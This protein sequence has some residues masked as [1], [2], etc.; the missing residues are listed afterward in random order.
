MKWTLF[1]VVTLA[2]ISIGCQQNNTPKLNAGKQFENPADS[3]NELIKESP[4]DAQLYFERAQLHYA[5]RDVASSL[6]DV[7]R[8][9]KLDSGNVEFYILLA[10]L[11]L[12]NK[13][14]RD[15]KDALLKAYRINPTDTRV[16]LKLGELYMIVND[17]DASFRYLNEALQQ[18]IHLAEAYRLKGFN[19]K[20]SGDTTNAVSSFQ[21]AI[22]QDPDDYDSYLQLGL[23][24]SSILNPLAL[25]Y[26]DN[27][28]RVRPASLEAMYAKALHLQ[29]IGESR[30]AIRLYDQ[31]IEANPNFFNAHYNKGFVYLEQ[32]EKY[33]SAA[34]A[35]TQ[36]INYGPENYF[37]A[38]YNR[39]LANERMGNKT[40]AKEDYKLALKQN[41]QYDLAA[42][43][44][45]RVGQ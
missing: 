42:H 20:Y 8:A 18:D 7:G 5:N 38:V 17:Y 13:Q 1:L 6:S 34:V 15:S 12:I 24:Y 14:S 10:N 30:L 25:N 39:G 26:Y 3:I 35:F 27:A 11:K 41:P 2:V 19:Y 4:N 43:G 22:E 32:L 28:L 9:L 29:N 45:S 36:A 21:T 40:S 31:I 44:L 23:I 33:D 16:L 37:Q